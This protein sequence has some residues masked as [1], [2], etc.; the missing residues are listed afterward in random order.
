[1]IHRISQT[2]RPSSPHNGEFV[3]LYCIYV[4]CCCNVYVKQQTISEK[5]FA[6][7]TKIAR[8]LSN[9]CLTARS[10]LNPVLGPLEV[11]IKHPQRVFDVHYIGDQIARFKSN[12]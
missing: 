11:T 4:E 3:G 8:Q 10:G 1:M 6:N 9:G 7:R 12:M 2:Q 5:T